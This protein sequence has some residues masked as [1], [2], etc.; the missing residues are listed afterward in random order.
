[1]AWKELRR[2]ALDSETTTQAVREE[3]AVNLL[4]AKHGLNRSA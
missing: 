3:E 2:P 4:L 1:L